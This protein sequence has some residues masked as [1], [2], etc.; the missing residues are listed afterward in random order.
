MKVISIAI[1]LENEIGTRQNV[2]PNEDTTKTS[3][4]YSLTRSKNFGNEVKKRIL[5][6]SYALTAEYVL[7][8]SNKWDE[9]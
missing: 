6:G 2:P 8:S 9:V 4:V 1:F 7:P 3:N 5:L